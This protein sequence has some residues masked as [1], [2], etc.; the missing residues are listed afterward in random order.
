MA[1]RLPRRILLALRSFVRHGTAERE[2]DEELRFHFEQM[3]AHEAA[4][5]A[6]QGASGNTSK[7]RPS[8]RR[9][10]GSAVSIR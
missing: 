7:T 6:S 5:R 4:R 9:A 8:P 3:A 1:G 10:A 2:L